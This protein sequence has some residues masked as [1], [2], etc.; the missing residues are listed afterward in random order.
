MKLA[1]GNHGETAERRVRYPAYLDADAVLRDGSTLHIRPVVP[2]DRAALAAFLA[3]LSDES[4]IFRF[5]SPVRELDWAA[6]R[7]TDVDYVN[8]H[9]LLA[10]RGDPEV[11]VG[12]GLYMRT[13]PDRAE[14]AFAVADELQGHGLGTILL[15]LLADEADRAGISIF[16]AEVLPENQKVLGVFRDSGFPARSRTVDGVIEIE[17]PT[18][19]TPAALD[20]FEERSKQAAVAALRHFFEPEAIAVIGASS[21]RGSIG[22]DLFANLLLSGFPGPVYPVSP[23]PVVQSV[24]AYPEVS[25]VPGPVDLAIIAVPAPEVVDVARQCAEKG[26][27]ALVVISAGFAEAGP[28]GRARQDELVA[29]CRAAGMRLIGPNCMGILSTSRE[30]PL[31]ATFAPNV[32]PVGGV[33]FMSQ[34]G[35]LGL[36]VIDHAAE[37]GLGIST[38]VSVGNKA[39]ISGNDLLD[40]WEE[41]AHTNLVM[42]Y[43]ESFGNPRR[44]S[45]IARRVARRKPIL[46]VKSGRSPAGTRATSSHTGALLAASDVTVDALFRQAGVIRAE[47]LGDLFD[48]ASLLVN[49]PLPA[50]RRVGILTNA[51][52]LGIL[53]ADACAAGGL[54]V[55]VLRSATTGRLSEFL[56]PA[57]SLANPVDLLASATSEQYARA[58]AVLGESRD[59]DSLVVIFIPPLA[60]HA[61]EV[62]TAI[63]QAADRIRGQKPVLLVVMHRESRLLAG[64]KLPSFTF[65]EDAA[66]ALAMVQDWVDWRRRQQEDPEGAVVEPDGLRRPDARRIIARALGAGGGWLSFSDAS[67]LLACYGIE[68]AASAEART[69]AEVSA[70]ARRLGPGP[71]V[72]K[73]LAPELVHKTE[74]GAVAL[75]L[76]GPRAVR[77]E[78]EAMADR[79]AAA[80]KPVESFLVQAMVEQGVEMIVGVVQDPVFGPVLAC[81]AGGTAVELVKD[82]QVRLTPLT[83]SEA[84]G[85]IEALKTYPL[86]RGYRGRPPANVEA[87]IDLLLRVSAMVEAHQ[88]IAEMDLNPVICGPSAAPVVDVRIRIA[89]I[90]PPPAEGARRRPQSNAR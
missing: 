23:H 31:N 29:V 56:P 13:G 2:E 8:R 4:R 90:A 19:L 88:E 38:F 14:V 16:Y 30:R 87:L 74:A 70:A 49:A 36:A 18:S 21:K 11:I 25:K 61:G 86:L 80:G 54:E 50:G 12:H 66:R 46:A 26:V 39:D 89:D 53:C 58:I 5:F 71:F 65:P 1:A 79:L 37:I 83:R 75:G 22:G 57:A 45:R 40:F 85:I 59:V 62:V 78:A 82:I 15:G 72:L 42:L 10:L 73:G 20:E 60:E 32:P 84:R 7:F 69:V 48:V 47:S 44:F 6:R 67:A 3:G 64:Q 41:D 28:E 27:R 76:T 51:G 81:G 43:L 52:G 9:G 68:L 35:A 24:L 63:K 34:S 17:M 55:P 77:R 33:G